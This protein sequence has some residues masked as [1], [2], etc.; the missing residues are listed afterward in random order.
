MKRLLLALSV[1]MLILSGCATKYIEIQNVECRIPF[2]RAHLIIAANPFF[3]SFSNPAWA[4][5]TPNICSINEAASTMDAP[6]WP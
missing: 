5:K 2:S 3:C 4:T 6:Y 1:V